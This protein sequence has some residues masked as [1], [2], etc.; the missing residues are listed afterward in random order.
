MTNNTDYKLTEQIFSYRFATIGHSGLIR[1]RSFEEAKGMFNRLLPQEAV[2]KGESGWIEDKNGVFFC[3][4]SDPDRAT[5]QPA[6]HR[7]H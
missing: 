6:S 7:R 3:L 1:A 2:S 5:W 4:G